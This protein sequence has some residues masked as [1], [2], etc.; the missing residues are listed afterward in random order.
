LKFSKP[1][2]LSLER[3]FNPKRSLLTLSFV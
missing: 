3:A 2:L 1:K